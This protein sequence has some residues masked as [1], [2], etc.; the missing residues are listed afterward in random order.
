MF[1]LTHLSQL[2][3]ILG[4]FFLCGYAL[5]WEF[6]KGSSKVLA[7]FDVFSSSLNNWNGLRHAENFF[8]NETSPFDAHEGN[9]IFGMRPWIEKEYPK[10]KTLVKG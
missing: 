7:I 8:I 3:D 10:Q 5:G 6:E 1:W 9:H 2:F 4:F